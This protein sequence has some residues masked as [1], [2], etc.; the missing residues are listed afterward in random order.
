MAAPPPTPP[1][2]PAPAFQAAAFQA[3]AFQP[4]PRAGL[5]E[6]FARHPVACNLLMAI[7]LLV[8][9]AALTRLNPETPP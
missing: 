8:G 1:V 5:I 7:M 9:A 6:A 4:A 2:P 3:A